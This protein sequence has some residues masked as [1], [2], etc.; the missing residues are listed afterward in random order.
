[1]GY[2]C[3]AFLKL[4]PMMVYYSVDRQQYTPAE[5]AVDYAYYVPFYYYVY[6]MNDEGLMLVYVIVDALVLLKSKGLLM[7]MIG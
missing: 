2:P 1:M 5:A 3:W 6:P 4:M 7:M